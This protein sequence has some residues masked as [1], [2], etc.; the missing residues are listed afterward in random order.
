MK[1]N[2]L[3]GLLASVYAMILL[4]VLI[5]NFTSRTSES[6]RFFY[7]FTQQSNII[8]L[9]WLVLFSVN[10]F[11]PKRFKFVTNKTLMVAITTYIS[12][13]FFIVT[14]I[15][16]PFYLG[17]FSPASSTGE[18]FLHNLTPIVM[19]I[20]FFTVKTKDDLPLKKTPLVLIYPLIYVILNLI[21]GYTVTYED[22][23]MAF[24]YGFTNPNNY[25]NIFMFIIA[26]IGLVIVFSLFS[27]SL[28]K[29]KKWIDTNI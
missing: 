7:A 1:N 16:E 10:V 22:G 20:Y 11:S 18:L 4:M 2:V 8:V 17:K 5:S 9:I 12:I 14:F 29:L 28:S 27:I 3:K 19:W 25:G 15:L 13:T 26:I 24:A 21:I 23:S 6:W